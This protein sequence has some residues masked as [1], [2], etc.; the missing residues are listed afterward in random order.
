MLYAVI[1][2]GGS[3]TRF[4]PV[5]RQQRPK[6]L[7][8]LTPGGTMLRQTVDRLEGLVLPSQC[9]VVTGE[10]LAAEVASQLPQLPAENVVAEPCRRDTAPCIGLAALLVS[11]IDPE[12][13][14][15]VM[16]ADHVIEPR[17][18]FHSAIRQAEMLIEADPTLMVTFG[19][20]PT[21]AAQVFGYIERDA[22]LA[23]STNDDFAPTYHVGRFREK[24]DAETATEYLKSGEFYWNSGIFVW[25]AST[26]LAA[27]EV[28]QPRMLAQLRNIADAWGTDHRD[29]ILHRQFEAIEPISIDYAV[30]EQASNVVVVESPFE[31]D[32]LGGWQS[33]SRRLGVDENENTAQ[34]RFLGINTAG[35]I[36]KTSNDHLVVTLGVHNM[37]VVHTPDVTLVAAKQDEEAIRLLVKELEQRGWNDVL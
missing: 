10:K 20:K 16:P 24:P 12:A 25:R 32:D 4:W 27:L 23:L 28:H 17:E 29:E 2:A 3:G 11:R 37:I 9:F 26:I 15:V 30:M 1:M 34:G 7:L 14:L 36:I 22:P 31:W 6:Q 8:E 5:S 19:I 33:L 21:Y 35:S 13:T 18:A